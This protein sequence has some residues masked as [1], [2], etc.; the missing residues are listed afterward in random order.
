M[1]IAFG[2]ISAS[3]SNYLKFKNTAASSVIRASEAF[4][5]EIKHQF[6]LNF[7]PTSFASGGPT[8]ELQTYISPL[9]GYNAPLQAYNALL[10]AYNAALQ[11]YN[12]ALQAYNAALQA[13]NSIL[14]AYNS[15]LQ[16]Y[17]SEIGACKMEIVIHFAFS[18]L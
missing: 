8:S 2:F 3:T 5:S 11:A 15:I 18:G 6:I 9:Q 13:Y 16:A 17:N 14:Q 4:P 1:K 7:N 10:Q 12:A